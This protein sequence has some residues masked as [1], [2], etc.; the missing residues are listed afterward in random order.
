MILTR[1]TT[2]IVNGYIHTLPTKSLIYSEMYFQV[3][4]QYQDGSS[5]QLLQSSQLGVAVEPSRMI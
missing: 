1:Y 2:H 3:V 4:E 5:H